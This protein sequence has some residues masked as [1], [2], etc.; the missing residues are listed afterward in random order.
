MYIC[1]S[2]SSHCGAFRPGLNPQD[3]YKAGQDIHMRWR[4]RELWQLC[5]LGYDRHLASQLHGPDQE[6]TVV[7]VR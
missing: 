2:H 1:M 3:R 7:G 5:Q 4:H 6:G